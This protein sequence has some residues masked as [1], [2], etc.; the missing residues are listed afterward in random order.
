[1]IKAVS[2]ARNLPRINEIRH[3][4]Q[5]HGFGFVLRRYAL[6]R[7]ILTLRRVPEE[8]RLPAH[9][10]DELRKILEELGPTYIKLGQ[11]LS[12]RPDILPPEAILALRL[13]RDEVTPVPFD[14]IRP[15]IEEELGGKV[16]DLFEKLDEIPIGSASIG[17]AYVAF[18]G[19]QKVA[20]KVQRPRARAQVEADLRVLADLADWLKRNW[21]QDLFFDP[22][23]LLDEVRSFLYSELDY[24]EEARNTE[25]FAEDFRED[26]RVRIPQVHWDRT[27][28]RVITTEFLDGTPLSRLRPETYSLEDRRNLAI[29]G[30]Q[31]SMEQVFEHGFFHGDPHPSNIFVMGPN[32]YGLIDFGLVGFLSERDLRVMTDYLI[33]L[34]RNQTDR[35][36]R[37]LKALGVVIPHQYE[38]DVASAFSGIIRRYYG[39]TLAQIDTT[40]LV[41]ELLEI[42]Y[43]YKIRLPTKYILILRGL[44]TVEGTGRELYPDFNV[45]E[46]AEPYVRRMALRRFSPRVLASENL[47]RAGE[48]VDV[49]SRY[50]YQVS[51]VL[52]EL[53]ETLR[54]TRRIEEWIDSSTSKAAKYTNRLAA[55]IFAVGLLVAATQVHFG[56]KVFDI[57]LFSMFLFAVCLFW[58]FWLFYGILRTGGL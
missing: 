14:E 46:V 15:V 1:M 3:V 28:A 44:T 16:E 11:V 9:W 56:P 37:D 32:Q 7:F 40:R 29:L 30:A 6:G 42:F 20:V 12:V 54:E 55:A 22:V 21:G 47:E 36:V 52:E 58:G 17:Q 5:R 19:G 39:V 31:V 35:L 38:D 8:Q 45:F 41:T 2:R 18:H 48:V 34:I 51:D 24:V 27:T 25:R 49:F 33:H 23:K 43:R 50:P 13:L 4:L 26:P 10:G 53:Q 57:P